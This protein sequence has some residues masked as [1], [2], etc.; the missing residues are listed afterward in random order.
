FNDADTRQTAYATG[1]AQLTYAPAGGHLQISAFVRNF[2]DNAVFANATRN[3]TAI[4]SINTYQF[5]PPR[6]YG[7]R[8][9]FK[10]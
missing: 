6:T 8:L 5:Q 3:F 2:T 10:Y 1:N 4:P 7:M 9:S